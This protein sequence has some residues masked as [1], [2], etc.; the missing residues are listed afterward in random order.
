M[1][2]NQYILSFAYK[3][4]WEYNTTH[5]LSVVKIW[6]KYVVNLSFYHQR[7]FIWYGY[8]AQSPLS[9]VTFH[10]VIDFH[11]YSLYFNTLLT[12]YTEVKYQP[13]QY[14]FYMY[15]KFDELLSEIDNV[16]KNEEFNLTLSTYYA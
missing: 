5:V 12:K 16:Y 15:I 4:Y 13:K 14:F 9:S 6:A 2:W 8:P 10:N 7:Q 11:S 3:F 1:R